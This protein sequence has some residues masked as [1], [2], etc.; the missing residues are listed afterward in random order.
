MLLAEACQLAQS[1]TGV[2]VMPLPDTED[3]VVFCEKHRF[4]PDQEYMLPQ[5]LKHL[6]DALSPTEIIVALDSFQIRFVFFLAEDTPV[7]VGPFCTEFFSL[8]DCSTLLRQRGL[9]LPPRDLL[10][11]RGAIPVCPESEMLHIARTLI[12]YLESD[13]NQRVVRRLGFDKAVVTINE[14]ATHKTYAQIIQERYRIETEFMDNIRQGNSNA[15]IE[16]WRYLHNSVEYMKSLG[17]PLETARM[18]A[19]ITR[20]TMRI[21]AMEAGLPAV[22]NDQISGQSTKNV[23]QAAS[24]DAINQEH[25][26]LIR[27]YCREIRT[28]KESGRSSLVVSA[29]Y[30]MEC[31]PAN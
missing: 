20:T 21:A 14:A 19:A 22:L 13:H 3:L 7:A 8:N 29:V 16:N 24:I 23:K 1:L 26:R 5:A 4:H 6:F 10:A 31:C 2:Y 17:Q 11:W 12:S 18:S 25:M 9:S 30:Q 27:E 28:Q 15:A